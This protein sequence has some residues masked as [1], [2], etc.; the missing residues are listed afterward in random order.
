LLIAKNQPSEDWD[1][2]T[3]RQARQI[4]RLLGKLLWEKNVIRLEELAQHHFAG[5][6]ELL[7]EVA[8]SY[9]KSPKDELRSTAEL[10][11]IGGS[12]PSAKRGIKAGTLNRH[13]T[14]L[15]QLLVYLRGQGL[16][17]D[18]DIDISLLRPKTRNQR[19]SDKRATFSN[20]ELAEI[21]NLA[22][23]T[24]CAGWKGAEAFS[25]GSQIF[26]CALYFATILLYYT[27]ARREEICGLAI[28]DVQTPELE[29]G[30]EKKPAPSLF[31][32]KNEA[33]RLKNVQSM[34]LIALVPEVVQLGFLDYVAE[35]RKLGYTL[36]FPDLRSPT[37]SS[38]MGDRLYDELKRGIDKVIPDASARKKVLHSFRKTFGD[39]LK[40]AG[41]HAE[42]RGDI[43]SHGGGAV[44]EEIYCDPIALSA[45][46][47]HLRKLPIVTAHLEPR[48]INL[49]PW[50][51]EKVTPPHAR[52]RAK[53][54]L[55]QLAPQTAPSAAR[56]REQSRH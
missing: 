52:Q 46:L 30:G 35:I 6:V 38:P 1:V 24:G 40:Q 33:R 31:I 17:I 27:G 47:D 49:L 32:R 7:G 12:K 4:F 9:G 29:I 39:S 16:K 34:R 37:S 41:V 13:L 51:A 3:C 36:V 20:N 43:L 44:T 53:R 14:F 54:R 2:K 25:P 19:G 45:M 42:I 28:V 23:F 56:L 15:G 8:T 21:F 5:L 26:H 48:P 18:R 22:C 10:R 11:D 55:D 50:V